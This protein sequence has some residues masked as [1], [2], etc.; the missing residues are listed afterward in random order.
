M[1]DGSGRPLAGKLG[2][3]NLRKDFWECEMWTVDNTVDRGKID[4]RSL[5]E[6]NSSRFLSVF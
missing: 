3:V 2:R 5:F 4:P 1:H 6:S